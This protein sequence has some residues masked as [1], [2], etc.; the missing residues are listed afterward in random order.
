MEAAHAPI[1]VNASS[2]NRK[3][4]LHPRLN[5][6]LVAGPAPSPEDL[7]TFGRDQEFAAPSSQ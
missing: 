6:R 5:P 1:T 2:T 3:A 4:Y 7:A